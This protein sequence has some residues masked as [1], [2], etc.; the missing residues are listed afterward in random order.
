[1]NK[2]GSVAKVK[3]IDHIAGETTCDLILYSRAGTKIGRES[4]AMGGPRT[5]EPCCSIDGW[6]RCVEPS[7]PLGLQWV[8][9][10]DG[11]RMAMYWVKRLPPANWRKPKARV[12]ALRIPQDAALRRALEQD[13]KST[14][15]NSSH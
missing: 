12:R 8:T 14:R 1:M 9:Q 7:F 2:S 4:P 10:P 13:R 6:E 11:S 3:A 15:L 5:F